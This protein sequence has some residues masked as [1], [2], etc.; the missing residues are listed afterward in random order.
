MCKGLNLRASFCVLVELF[1]FPV[2]FNNVSTLL[3]LLF[4]LLHGGMRDGGCAAA[5]HPTCSCGV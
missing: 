2:G 3:F 4:L 1:F 5:A